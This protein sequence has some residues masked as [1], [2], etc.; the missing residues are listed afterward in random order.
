LRTADAA[1]RKLAKDAGYKLP[2]EK[3]QPNSGKNSGTIVILAIRL[4]D[5]AVIAII[6]AAG[7][8]LIAGIELLRRARRRRS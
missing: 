3:A 2:T 7:T 8:L 4:S 1:V 6:A 5:T